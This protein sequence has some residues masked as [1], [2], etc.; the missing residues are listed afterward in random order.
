MGGISADVGRFQ[1]L[2]A[3]GG[4]APPNRPGSPPTDAA[5]SDG[6]GIVERVDDYCATSYVYCRRPQSV[7]RLDI[8]AAVADIGRRDYEQPT[9]IET[10]MAGM[11][12]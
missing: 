6:G 11:L 1:Q 9:A 8:A 2:Q 3:D 4:V 5:V 12:A 10:M 7:P